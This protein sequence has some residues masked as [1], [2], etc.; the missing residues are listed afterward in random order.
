VKNGKIM[1]HTDNYIQVQV[2]GEIDLINTINNILLSENNDM[3]V[4]GILA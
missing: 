1:G 4:N 3:I 2:N